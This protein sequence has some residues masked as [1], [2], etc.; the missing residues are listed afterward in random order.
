MFLNDKFKFNERNTTLSTEILAG[1]TTFVSMSYII[2]VN[3]SVLNK[4]GMDFHGVFVATILASIVGTLIMGLIANYPI[5]IAPGMGMNAYFA[6]VIVLGM[7]IP[8]QSALGSVFIASVIFLLLSLTGFRQS[9]IEAIPISLKAGISGGIG[10]FIAFIGMQNAHLVVASPATIITLGNFSEPVA[11]MSILGLI[12]TIIL[13][14]N[15]VPAAIFL[16][17]LITAIVSFCLGYI[18][19]PH[20]ILSL[21]TGLD[22]T[23][24][25][26]DIAGAFSPN[27]FAI[28]FTFFLVT[29]FDTTGTMIGVA[30]QAGLM[31]N[32]HFPN[33]KSALLAD[34]VASTIGS[35]FGTSPTS[36]YVESGTGV[37]AGGRTGFTAVVVA[38]LFFCML[39]FAPVAQV[40][41]SAP[42]ITSPALIIVGFLMMGNLNQVNWTDIEESLPAF[43]VL[44]WMPLSYSITNGVGAGLILYPLIKI[45]RGKYRQVHPL[46]YV[47][48]VL[49]VIQ[50]IMMNH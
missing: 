19:L 43:F 50:F 6:F 39:F 10:L 42:A 26:L 41:A 49:F 9:L 47:F 21:P 13:L 4:T 38:F 31:K 32:G 17:M 16:G 40:L 23:F 12:V 2:I 22:A 46:L 7:G 36:S 14:V 11:Y 33:V 44:F 48:L 8:W 37:A 3:P 34:A 29:L 1:I 18:P 15:D 35:I 27:L 20:S 30:S 45:F 24:M 5:A 28:I 25:H